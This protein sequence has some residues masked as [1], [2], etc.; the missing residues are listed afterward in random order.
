[1]HD[2][3]AVRSYSPVVTSGHAQDH[4]FPSNRQTNTDKLHPYMRA[5]NM[6]Y[7]VRPYT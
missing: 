1:M 2:T 3:K 4:P 5:Q 7:S 6:L